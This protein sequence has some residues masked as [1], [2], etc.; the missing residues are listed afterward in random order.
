MSTQRIQQGLVV[1]LLLAAAALLAHNYFA[2]GQAPAAPKTAGQIVEYSALR[3]IKPISKGAV[4]APGDIETVQSGTPPAAGT[5]AS[6]A[7]L[8]DRIA[9]R[10]IAA[11][12]FLTRTNTV[13]VPRPVTLADAIPAGLRAISVHIDDDS[14]VAELLHPGDHVDILIVSHADR[15]ALAPGQ[16]FP[17]AEV[18]TLLQDVPVLAVGASMERNAAAPHNVRNIVLAV[19]P[20]SAAAVALVKSIGHE[21]LALRRNGDEAIVPAPS[22]TTAGLGLEAAPAPKSSE[23]QIR[24]PAHTIEIIRGPAAAPAHSAGGPS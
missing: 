15:A 19:A 13:L 6:P 18:R 16:M 17:Q 22:M 1:G 11:N 24:A 4:I 14:G 2:A 7:E 5:F 9:A 23:S 20:Q 12:E 10:A 21:Y 8:K 3:A